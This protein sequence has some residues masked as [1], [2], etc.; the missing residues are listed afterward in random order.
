MTERS[1]ASTNHQGILSIHM[2]PRSP[3][4]NAI[5]PNPQTT[6]LSTAKRS[7]AGLAHCCPPSTDLGQCL[8]RR[9]VC[10]ASFVTSAGHYFGHR[11]T[12]AYAATGGDTTDRPCTT[13]LDGALLLKHLVGRPEAI[14]AWILAS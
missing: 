10:K 14:V 3:P 6:L 9:F 12:Q 8:C 11:S 5:L 4:L 2:G 7:F 13:P 1:E